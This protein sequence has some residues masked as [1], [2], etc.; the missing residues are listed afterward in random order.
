MCRRS[1]QESVG[2]EHLEQFPYVNAVISESMRMWPPVTPFIGLQR[3]ANQN[4]ELGGYAIPRGSTLWLNVL[5]IHRDERHYPEPE[6]CAHRRQ[7]VIN[8]AVNDATLT[9]QVQY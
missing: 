6:V 9:L 1:G 2:Y 7:C 3:A 4:S 8:K 5:A